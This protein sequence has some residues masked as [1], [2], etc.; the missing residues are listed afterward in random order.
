VPERREAG[1]RGERVPFRVPLTY[2]CV[3]LP[4]TVSVSTLL[5]PATAPI[6]SPPPIVFANVVS[7]GMTP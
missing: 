6:G 5:F 1:G 7:S 2:E 4:G 3:E